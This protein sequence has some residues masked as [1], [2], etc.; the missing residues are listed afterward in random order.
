MSSKFTRRD[1]LKL[2]GLSVAGLAFSPYL[3][4]HWGSFDDSN[5]VR[6]APT[7]VSVYKE[8]TDKSLITGTWYRDD[9]IHVYEEVVAKEP[10]YNPVWYHVWGGYMHRSRVHSAPPSQGFRRTQIC[11]CAWFPHLI[12]RY[13]SREGHNMLPDALGSI[14]PAPRAIYERVVRSMS[15]T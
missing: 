7:S 12:A 3:P 8:P 10:V 4:A 11:K 1:F 6:V 14:H 15:W 13:T 2:G 9:L 5:V